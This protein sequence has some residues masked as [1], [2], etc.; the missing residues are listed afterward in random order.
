MDA[1]HVRANGL[2][3]V[4]MRWRSTRACTS[5]DLS[6]VAKGSRESSGS[7][8]LVVVRSTSKLQRSLQGGCQARLEMQRQ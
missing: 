7:F 2:Q 3:S 4:I 1:G 5:Y 8:G 6:A